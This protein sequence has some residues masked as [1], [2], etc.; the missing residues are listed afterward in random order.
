MELALNV[1]K[2]ELKDIIKDAVREVIEE[3]S[4][5]RFMKS[6][7]YVSD[8]EMEEIENNYDRPD[9]DVYYSE[10]LEI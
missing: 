7:E 2:E 9:E 10:E 1:S 3:S 6:L 8:K 4:W 5:E